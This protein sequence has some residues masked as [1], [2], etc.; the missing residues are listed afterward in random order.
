MI[1]DVYVCCILL[2]VFMGFCSLVSILECNLV[3][4]LFWWVG[5]NFKKIKNIFNFGVYIVFD[6]F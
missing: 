3:G 1:V 4:N 2:G 6:V 5:F